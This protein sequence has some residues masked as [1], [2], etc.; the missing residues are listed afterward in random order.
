MRQGA[1]LSGWPWLFLI[2]AIPSIVFG[3]AILFY[4]DDNLK[5]DKWLDADEKQRVATIM[6]GEKEEKE[7]LSELRHAFV[8]GRLAGRGLFLHRQRHLYRKLLDPNHHQTNRHYRPVED[9]IAYSY[10][11]SCRRGVDDCGVR[12]RRPHEGAQVAHGDAGCRMRSRAF[13]TA[14]ATGNT[15]LALI[16][17]TLAAAGA[18]TSQASFWTLPLPFSAGRPR[19]RGSRSSTRSATS[20]ALR[21]PISSVGWPI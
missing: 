11:L 6:A 8:T 12:S 9:W 15:L 19:P 21:A 2:E 17:L 16:G 7:G 1:G 5:D 14:A 13:V 3:V 10:S 20:P 4:L 18:S